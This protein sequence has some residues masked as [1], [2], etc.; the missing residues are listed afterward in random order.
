MEIIWLGHAS[1]KIKT[2]GGVIYIDPYFGE[3]N[4]KAD[5]ILISHGHYDHSSMEKIGSVR[6]DDTVI[7]TTAEVA[8]TIHGAIAM[9]AGQIEEIEGVKVEAV[10]AYNINKNFHPKGYGLGFVV[11]A[12]GK[13]I[14][15]AGD[16]D[17]IPEMKSVKADIVLLPVGGTY[18]MNSSEAAMAV[19]DVKPKIAIPMHYG[20][21][22]VGTIED[23]E[24][25]K[26]KVEEKSSVRV[27][28]LEGGKGLKV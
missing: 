11:E 19:L 13:R 20:S 4:E 10:N 27:V 1:F 7:L 28:I 26:E 25:F 15:F 8:S 3:Y 24:V 17:R 5:I 9:T 22:I 6:T 16:T 18:T 12:E 23:A 14:Y 21:G 2:D